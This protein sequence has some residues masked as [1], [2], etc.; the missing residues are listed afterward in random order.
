MNADPTPPAPDVLKPPTA[1]PPAPEVL[2]VD[3]S[4]GTAAARALGRP[5]GGN[6]D[7]LE[8]IYIGHIARDVS[9]ELLKKVLLQCGTIAKWTRS[10]DPMT[11]APTS[12]GFCEFESPEAVWRVTRLI[13]G[14]T[15]GGQQLT[16]TCPAKTREL[17]DRWHSQRLYHLQKANPSWTSEMVEQ[18][19]R[20]DDERVKSIVDTIATDIEQAI[21]K[22]KAEREAEEAAKQIRM[23]AMKA[24]LNDR[25]DGGAALHQGRKKSRLSDGTAKNHDDHV[26][27]PYGV[28]P[29][30]AHREARRIETVKQRM[31]DLASEYEKRAKRW[32]DELPSVLAD[33]HRKE[34]RFE[35]NVARSTPSR[36]VVLQMVEC[37][38]RGVQYQISMPYLESLGRSMYYDVDARELLDTAPREQDEDGIPLSRNWQKKAL[39]E[40]ARMRDIEKKEDANDV[41]YEAREAAG[42][43]E[44]EA[45]LAIIKKRREA[46][47]GPDKPVEVREI[48]EEAP[49]KDK[50]AITVDWIE[51]KSSGFLDKDGPLKQWL[52]SQMEEYVGKDDSAELAEYIMD[53]LPPEAAIIPTEESLIK[54]LSEFLEDETEPFVK[55]LWKKMGTKE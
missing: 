32:N 28:P 27:S 42:V 48:E 34:R 37:D 51:L 29:A 3:F 26:S 19:F 15:L 11:D 43:K 12:F 49:V 38:L 54:E 52:V 30:I 36:R 33:I 20:Q 31:T 35:E 13:N 39:T 9:D 21:V 23:A 24:R 55:T 46:K 4:A 44:L 40:R 53:L 5:F 17:V 8:A 41:E 16:V 1:T 45:R 18:E 7:R 14:L 50:D 22:N 25:R 2:R 47:L 10:R 6:Q